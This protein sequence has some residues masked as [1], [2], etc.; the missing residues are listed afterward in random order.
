MYVVCVRVRMH[1]SMA[2]CYI[3]LLAHLD[4]T[5]L[6]LAQSTNKL[7]T[8]GL[9]YGLDLHLVVTGSVGTIIEYNR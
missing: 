3:M 5:V 2:T 7:S 6:N 4:A 8:P 1:Y 9:E